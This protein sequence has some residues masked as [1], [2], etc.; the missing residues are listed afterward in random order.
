[1]N[2]PWN[3]A[4]FRK[5]LPAERA[6]DWMTM[7][8]PGPDGPG[9]SVAGGTS[10]VLFRQSDNKAAA[11]QLVEFL[12]DPQVQ[13]R[14]HAMTG[15]L[16]PRRSAWTHGELAADPYA[17]AFRQQLERARPAPRVP[18]WERI[19]QEMRLVGEQM[20]GGRY[21]VEEAAAELDRRAD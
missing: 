14:F 13:A 9:A 18:E 7:P 12:S 15:D 4:E 3:I 20:V 8:L 1:V 6:D 21:T 11:W 2:G 10:F 5:R 16:P 17:T 19:A